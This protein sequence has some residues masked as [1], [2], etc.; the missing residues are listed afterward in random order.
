MKARKAPFGATGTGWPSMARRAPPVPT[1]PKMNVL[2]RAVTAEPAG[3]WTT[4]MTRG[5]SAR[6]IAGE[7]TDGGWV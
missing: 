6:G 2:S 5:P 1:E 7:E 4:L 3:G